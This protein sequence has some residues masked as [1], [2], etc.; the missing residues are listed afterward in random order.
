MNSLLQSLFMT[1]EFR[2]ALYK[3]S[4][5]AESDPQPSECIP[6]QLQKLFGTLQLTNRDDIST[7][8][9]TK[10][11]GWGETDAFQQHDVQELCLLL[12]DALEVSMKGTDNEHLIE[13]LWNGKFS[14][15]VTCKECR[16]EN[17]PR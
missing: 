13:E 15:Y 9:L 8:A 1:P 12:F 3:W 17:A 4:F 14:D 16:T 2:S 10:S 5:R 7:E 11:F 6:L